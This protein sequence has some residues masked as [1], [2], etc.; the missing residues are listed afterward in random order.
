MRVLAI[1][2]A[3]NLCAACIFDEAAGVELGRAVLDL[4]GKGH[5]EALIGVIETALQAADCRYRDIGRIGVS[6]GPGSFTGVR[7]GVATARGLALALAVEA[8]GISALEAVAVEARAVSPGRPVLAVIPAGRGVVY[9]A[10]YDDTGALILGPSLLTEEAAAGHAGL[11]GTVL[12]GPAAA[13]LG[14]GGQLVHASG[15]SADVATYAR[16]AA[17]APAGSPK[18]RPLYLRPPDARPQSAP[19]AVGRKP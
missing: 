5:A 9:A 13:L 14:G 18:P 1:D 10:L 6:I 19:A 8:I 2:T 11:D 16:L 3:A 12:T 15:A 17:A 4:G 7:I